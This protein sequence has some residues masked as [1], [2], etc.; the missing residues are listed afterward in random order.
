MA[1]LTAS[2]SRLAIGAPL[3]LALETDDPIGDDELARLQLRLQGGR[4]AEVRLVE[5]QILRV[6]ERS[7]R[8][9]TVVPTVESGLYSLA[10]LGSTRVRSDLPLLLL[11]RTLYGNVAGALSEE[12]FLETRETAES[13]EDSITE[14]FRERTRQIALYDPDIFKAA[15]SLD[16]IRF[17]APVVG[18]LLSAP[19]FWVAD[20]LADE[21]LYLG[22]LGIRNAT[23]RL[24]AN[25]GRLQINLVL[26][27][28]NLNSRIVNY[29]ADPNNDFSLIARSGKLIGFRSEVQMLTEE[30]LSLSASFRFESLDQ[31]QSSASNPKDH[32]NFAAAAALIQEARH[33]ET[34]PVNEEPLTQYAEFEKA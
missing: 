2:K 17:A 3:L 30:S 29:I 1:S 16:N 25:A 21:Y 18:R 34:E 11:D 15:E 6:G 7:L 9:S 28:A 10:L 8:L 20:T 4:H 32:G 27:L 31:G 19:I 14:A 13:I 5:P 23:C 12:P 24:A 33:V 22:P 26:T